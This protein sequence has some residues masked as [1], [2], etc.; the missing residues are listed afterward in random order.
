MADLPRPEALDI[1]GWVAFQRGG[2]RAIPGGFD[3]ATAAELRASGWD[4]ER[5]GPVFSIDYSGRRKASA[6]GEAE[7]E[8]ELE[9]IQA[10]NARRARGE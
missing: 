1:E 5:D 8:K 4:I 2:I 3:S 7:V 6:E 10:E 9:R